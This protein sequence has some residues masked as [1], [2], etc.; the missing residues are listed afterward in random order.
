M[1]GWCLLCACEVCVCMC[2]CMCVYVCVCVRACVYVYGHDLS[3][4]PALSCYMT[5]L[6]KYLY[7][8]CFLSFAVY[9][10]R[11]KYEPGNSQLCLRISFLVACR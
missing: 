9:I 4:V 6:E 8:E 1:T 5:I 2:M 3:Y 7:W 11:L 10:S